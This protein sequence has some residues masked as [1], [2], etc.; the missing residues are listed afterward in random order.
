VGTAA[1]ARAAAAE[2]ASASR[3]ERRW[4]AAAGGAA[5]SGAGGAGDEAAPSAAAA[6]ARTLTERW[7]GRAAEVG[8]RAD[9]QPSPA[10]R[11]V[12]VRAIACFGDLGARA[13]DRKRG[14]RVD[15]GMLFCLFPK[16][17]SLSLS[18]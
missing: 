8:P 10:R 13:R 17:R 14:G 15:E 3:A 18:L 4:A 1:G 9:L 2:A 7:V 6:A 5:A 16:R 12:A 11:V